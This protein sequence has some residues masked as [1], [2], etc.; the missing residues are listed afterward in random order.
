MSRNG[1]S[2]I[3]VTASLA[4]MATLSAWA[5]PNILSYQ[6]VLSNSNGEAAADGLY[7]MQFDLFDAETAGASVWTESHAGVLV[8]D[9]AFGV[10]LGG[11]SP[12]SAQALAAAVPAHPGLWLQVTV[13]PQA[14]VP[15]V[16]LPRVALGSAPKA[17]STIAEEV[18]YDNGASGLAA[19]NVQ[20]ALDEVEDRIDILELGSPGGAV[21]SVFGRTGAVTAQA[22][23]YSAAQ[24][25]LTP[26][27]GVA[28]TDV[29]AAI[30]ELDAEKAA[31]VHTHNLQDLT[32]AVTDAQVP[33][34]ITVDLAASATTAANA[35]TLDGIDSTG[36]ALSG[37][38]HNL[39]DLGG[40]VTDAQVPDSITVD[41]ATSAGSATT[42]TNA[43]NANNAG[44]LDGIDSTG[45]ALSGHGHNLQDLG[46]AVTDA[47]VPNNV[48]VDLASDSNLLDSID[49]TGF[50]RSYNAPPIGAIIAWHKDF[51]GT[52]ALPTGWAECNGQTLSLAGSP[53]NGAT[54]P[55]LNGALTA[56]SGTATKGRFLRGH[57][58][59][60]QVE[61]D[62]DNSVQYVRTAGDDGAP[63]G[64]NVTLPANGGEVRTS[65]WYEGSRDSMFFKRFGREVRPLNFSV[66]WIIRVL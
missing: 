27:G 41:F 30:A 56:D 49:S 61:A 65:T 19:E 39:Q 57:T 29:Q 58:A 10:M 25:A 28:A 47:Q 23:D 63:V 42:A 20:E 26:A 9:G 35:E 54:L 1:F 13:T 51:A 34:T 48:T 7:D 53:Y 18:T 4:L 11:T 24:V 16:F 43:T 33:N 31:A 40:A 3:M 38:G 5:Q 46:G 44:T 17:L 15:E 60:G 2:R 37:H 64:S 12:A 55:N 8:T 14:G 21:A 62:Q 6:G 32:G 50:A 52:P 66:V 22:G 59:S 36:F 45:F